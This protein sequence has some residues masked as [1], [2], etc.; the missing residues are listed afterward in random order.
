MALE[1]DIDCPSCGESRTFY[2]TAATGLHLGQKTK[3]RCPECNYGFIE[4][5]GKSTLTA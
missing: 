3:W 2:R 4:I 1:R 5:D